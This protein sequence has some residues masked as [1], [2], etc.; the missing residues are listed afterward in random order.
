MRRF[1]TFV[2]ADNIDLILA[3]LIDKVGRL[4]HVIPNSCYAVVDIGTMQTS[5]PFARCRKCVIN[6]DTLAGPD[7]RNKQVS[8]LTPLKVVLFQA[9]VEHVVT[10]LLRLKFRCD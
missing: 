2:I 6:K 10:L 7:F 8:I 1:L 3:S 4:V 9:G 5:P